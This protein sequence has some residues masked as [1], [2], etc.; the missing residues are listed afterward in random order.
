MYASIKTLLLYLA[1]G[2]RPPTQTS[3][4]NRWLVTAALLTR[5]ATVHNE[6]SEVRRKALLIAMQSN[7]GLDDRTSTCLLA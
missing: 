5:V 1:G 7:F 4:Y 2:A 3:D 6:M